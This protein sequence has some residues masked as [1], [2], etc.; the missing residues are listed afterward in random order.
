MRLSETNRDKGEN[1]TQRIE[2]FWHRVYV[3]VN[4]KLIS[5]CQKRI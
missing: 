3:H 4:E 1:N 5:L 2:V